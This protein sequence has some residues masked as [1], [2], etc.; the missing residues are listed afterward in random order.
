VRT[1][2]SQ[3]EKQ[4]VFEGMA[5]RSSNEAY[6]RVTRTFSVVQV[7]SESGQPPRAMKFLSTAGKKSEGLRLAALAA[8]S[9]SPHSV[10]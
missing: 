7:S 3:F 10:K 8:S 1:K 6:D 2:T 5:C 9:K 4:A